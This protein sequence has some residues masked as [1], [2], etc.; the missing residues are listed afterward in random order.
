MRIFFIAICLLFV[1]ISFAQKSYKD[2]IESY[3]KKYVKEHEVLSGKDKESCLFFQ[4]MKN[5]G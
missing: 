1:H 5:T 3:F 2:S 4:L